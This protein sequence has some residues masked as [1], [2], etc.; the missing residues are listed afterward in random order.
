M[1]S[2]VTLLDDV[3]WLVSNDLYLTPFDNPKRSDFAVVQNERM[4]LLNKET[5]NNRHA[6]L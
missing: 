4:T 3:T 6:R 2:L 5:N 1:Y